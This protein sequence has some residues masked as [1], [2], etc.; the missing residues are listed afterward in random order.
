MKSK[1]KKPLEEDDFVTLSKSEMRKLRKQLEDYHDP[2]RYLLVSEFDP[3]FR[4]FK[5]YYNLSE[6]TY[7]LEDPKHATLFK[8]RKTALAVKRLLSSRVKI[9]QCRTR[10]VKG[11]RV[12]VASSLPARSRGRKK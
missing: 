8:R 9:V 7:V 6:D 2:T 5:L 1:A 3:T 12:P 10:R 11:E 4:G